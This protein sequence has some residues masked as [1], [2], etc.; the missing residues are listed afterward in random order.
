MTAKMINAILAV[1]VFV[2][3][4]IPQREKLHQEIAMRKKVVFGCKVE[5]AINEAIKITA[6]WNFLKYF[7]CLKTSKKAAIAKIKPAGPKNSN[8]TLG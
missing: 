6:K 8:N 4:S 3:K 2:K 5:I 7:F 1:F